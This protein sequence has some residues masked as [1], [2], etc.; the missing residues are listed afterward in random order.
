MDKLTRVKVYVNVVETGSFTAAS[1]RM[2]ISRAAA[3]QYVAQLEDHLGGRLLNRTT[4]HISTTESGLMYYERCKEILHLL[5]E[6]DDMVSGLSGIPKGTLRISAPSVFAESHIVPIISDFTKKYPEVKVE[7]MVS[8]RNVDLVYEGYDLAIRATKIEDSELIARR[9]ASCKHVLIASPDF[10]KTRPPI[11][12]PE[13]LKQQDC[14]LY[15]YTTGAIWPIFKDGKDYSFKVS[16]LMTSNN[17]HVLLEAAIN[18][19]GISLMPTFIASDAIRQ[20]KLHTI[21]D[22]YE[23]LQLDIYAIYTSRHFLPAKIKTFV[24]Y[25]KAKITDPPYW[26]Y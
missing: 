16:P 17:P 1:E 3:S 19:M 24:D 7:L 2:G 22:D 4:R 18:G 11:L 6:A 25:L 26:D 13:D 20:G 14:L 23:S 10:L 15:S 21:L 9:L 8:D 5:E 12:T